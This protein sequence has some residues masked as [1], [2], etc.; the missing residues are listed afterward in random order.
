M[1]R[2]V[3]EVPSRPRMS[4]L[5]IPTPINDPIKVCEL[6]AGS[7]KYQVPSFAMVFALLIAVHIVNDYAVTGERIGK[8][9]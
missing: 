4:A 1:R 3:I 2:C 8:P 7:P 5:A 6:D 9:T